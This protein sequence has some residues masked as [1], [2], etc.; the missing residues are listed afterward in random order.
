M[1]KSGLAAP[2]SRGE[3]RRKVHAWERAPGGDLCEARDDETQT[4][5][6]GALFT[7]RSV[8]NDSAVTVEPPQKEGRN[9]LSR[10]NLP[11]ETFRSMPPDVQKHARLDSGRACAPI[12]CGLF[13]VKSKPVRLILTLRNQLEQQPN[14]PTRS[15]RSS[16][17]SCRL[18][19][20]RSTTRRCVRQMHAGDHANSSR[21]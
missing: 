19:T 14:I 13:V 10:P 17:A 18:L 9:L 8:A 20:G 12:P 5:N 16:H 4:Q 2:S 21:N 7:R 1:L 11:C 15:S 6:R 3:R